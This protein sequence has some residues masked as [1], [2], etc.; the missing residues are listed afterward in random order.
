MYKT[1]VVFFQPI[2]CCESISGRTC[3]AHRVVKEAT[4]DSLSCNSAFVSMHV[5]VPRTFYYQYWYRYLIFIIETIN[6]TFEAIRGLS[7]RCS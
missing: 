7:L 5:H 1:R 6:A 4:S 2:F 3:V